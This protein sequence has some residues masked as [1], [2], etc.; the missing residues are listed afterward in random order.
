MDAILRKALLQIVRKWET[1]VEQWQTVS[2]EV[3]AGLA[4]TALE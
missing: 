3:F 1:L 2:V 4:Q